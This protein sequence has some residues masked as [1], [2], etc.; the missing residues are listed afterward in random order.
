MYIFALP[1]PDQ[2]ENAANPNLVAFIADEE[3]LLSTLAGGIQDYIELNFV[4]ERI[5]VLGFSFNVA[6]INAACRST[7][8][9]DLLPP[10]LRS[11]DKLAVLSFDA[12]G[13]LR[14]HSS[15]ETDLAPF[16][17]AESIQKLGLFNIFDKRNGLLG[18]KDT[19]HYVKPS[20]AHCRSFLRT[21]QV[22]LN[23]S[24]I[25]FIACWILRYLKED[26]SHI[27]CDTAGIT[28]IAYAA[29]RLRG[30]LSPGFRHPRISSFSS[31]GGLELAPLDAASVV[32]ISASTAGKLAKDIQ[33]SAGLSEEQ[34]VTLY[35][36][37]GEAPSGIVLCDLTMGAPG[38]N[39][40]YPVAPN[41]SPEACPDCKNN[42]YPVRMKGEHFQPQDTDVKKLLIVDKDLPDWLGSF[43]ELC[44]GNNVIR[45]H[46]RRG[47]RG[48]IHEIFVDSYM[49]LSKVDKFNAKYNRVL[50]KSLPSSTRQIIHLGDKG[51]EEMATAAKGLL[52][53]S[54]NS[55]VSL[56]LASDLVKSPETYTSANGCSVV[57]AGCVA[58][59]RS[60]TEIG[61]VL[62]AIQP[63][64]GVVFLIGVSRMT[65]KK[66]AERLKSN[67]TY[68]S[69][70]SERFAYSELERIFVPDN[71]ATGASIWTKEVSLL[72][73]IRE[74]FFA[75]ETFPEGA[76]QT[77]IEWIQAAEGRDQRGML[78]QIFL[79]TMQGAHLQLR[80]NFAFMR[81]PYDG[82]KVTQA[83][84]FFIVSCILH[85]LRNS[86]DPKRWIRQEE[87]RRVILDPKTF[88][89][90]NDGIIQAALLRACLPTELDYRLDNLA[91]TEMADFL[92]E[93]FETSAN[94]RGEAAPEFLLA[95][96][97]GQMHLLSRD[98]V[99]VLE[100]AEKVVRANSM[101]EYLCRYLRSNKF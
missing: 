30:L 61:Q 77:R 43:S 18:S 6:Q 11:D 35:Y 48:E 76:V 90:L 67:L 70:T 92:V 8:F 40:G 14:R 60:L 62:R 93:I 3:V 23:G 38:L 1:F 32:I 64:H 72:Q 7:E 33:A 73:K 26:R 98:L 49:L 24:E 47:R 80:P 41:Y 88:D 96:A 66:E 31:Y 13:V 83:E 17:Q 59:G 45:A 78:N 34:V 39:L 16:E 79:P 53:N 46:H 71:T 86:T 4:P 68:I 27:W 91:S 82:G 69:G 100:A 36:L 21:A 22:L 74:M 52:C 55:G 56:V 75:H 37:Q 5:F 20:G 63:N 87:F 54:G 12:N 28:S 25:D 9:R 84:V 44:Y 19:F 81:F 51:S 15:D 95:L 57:V 99:T 89:R 65:E 42:S 29:A 101:E 10:L 2:H 50:I 85:E 97:L 58:S 94:A